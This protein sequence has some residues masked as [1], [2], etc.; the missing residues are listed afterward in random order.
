MT[1]I[2]KHWAL[3]RVEAMADRSLTAKERR[4]MRAA[5]AL[6]PQLRAAVEQAERLRHELRGLA[7]VGVPRSLHGRLLAIAVD[8]RLHALRRVPRWAPA[9]A[10]GAGAMVV[11]AL[12][13]MVL[14]RPEPPPPDE[15]L[16]A[17]REFEASM[18]YLQRSAEIARNE[19]TAA[20]GDGLRDALRTSREKMRDGEP[21]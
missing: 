9:F 19:V 15:Q 10:A 16:A 14:Q 2:E 6:D 12:A 1:D 20:V 3:S 8:P 13:T 7:D 5:M 4:R 18:V 17:L 21:E 11:A